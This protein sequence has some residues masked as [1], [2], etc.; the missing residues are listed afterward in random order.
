MKSIIEEY[1]EIPEMYIIKHKHDN[2]KNNGFDYTEKLLQKT[3]SPV[4]FVN[5]T[6]SE[7]LSYLNKQI[8]V[9]FDSL[10]PVRNIFFYSHSKYFNRHGK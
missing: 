8:V 5:D 1:N 3:L 6:N 9:M 10:L 7:F 2:L 4:L